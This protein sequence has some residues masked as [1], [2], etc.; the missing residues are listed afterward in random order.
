M[1]VVELGAD[2]GVEQNVAMF[3]CNVVQ[4][5]VRIDDLI[6]HHLDLLIS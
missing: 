1:D 5:V 3:V 6:H 4:D 2:C